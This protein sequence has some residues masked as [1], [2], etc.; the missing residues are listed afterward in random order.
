MIRT[1]PKLAL[2]ALSLPLTFGVGCKAKEHSAADIPKAPAAEVVMDAGPDH[3]LEIVTMTTVG[4]DSK[5]AALCGL[6]SNRVFFK[7]DSAKLSAETKDSLDSI[8]T[9]VATGAGKDVSLEVVG[10]TD[11]VGTD[12]YNQQLGMTRADAVAKYLREHGVAEPRVSTISKG[13]DDASVDPW[14]WPQARRV[15][16]RMKS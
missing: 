15:T 5:L 6:A 4:V 12:D 7:F 3:D 10:R 9:C 2:L 14:N 13:E 8:A 1:P 11:P 16:V